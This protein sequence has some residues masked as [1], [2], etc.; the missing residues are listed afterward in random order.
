MTNIDNIEL[1]KV[2]ADDLPPPSIVITVSANKML[3]Y[4]NV[5]TFSDEQEVTAQQVFDKLNDMEIVFGLD[6]NKVIEYCEK[7]KY[8]KEE[9][10][11]SGIKPQKGDDGYYKV[12]FNPDKDLKP[13]ELKDG[14][15]DY[16]DLDLITNVKA[17]EALCELFHFTEGV[18]GTDIYGKPAA[19]T[20]GKNP[21]WPMGK[22]T[23]LGEDDKYILA[24][25][26]G[27]VDIIGEKICV[28]ESMTITTDVGP[29]TGNIEFNG[30]ITI[31]GNV[32]DGY[33][34]K[35]TKCIVVKGVVEGAI[36]EAGEDITIGMGFS[37]MYKGKIKAGRNITAKYIENGTA[38]CRGI[39]RADFAMNSKI[40]SRDSVIMKGRKGAII[41][42]KIVVAQK[43]IAREIGSHSSNNTIVEIDEKW[44]EKE[45]GYISPQERRLQLEGE[46]SK[47]Q[48]NI[49]NTAE[50]IEKVRLIDPNDLDDA[51]KKNKM[52][53]THKLF[54]E[55]TAMMSQLK[56]LQSQ[57]E[58]IVIDEKQTQPKIVC[59]G[60]LHV[61][62]KVVINGIKL[63][64]DQESKN[65]KFYLHEGE[66]VSGQILPSDIEK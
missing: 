2:S 33:S 63:K 31:R 36:V 17:G 54:F 12:L 29:L 61:G 53:I 56:A 13:K 24:A 21:A 42:G 40:S 32:L 66:V 41:N 8:F 58:S 20:P 10:I 34:V 4:L 39:F 28:E 27:A 11:A 64:I 7:K 65:M 18:E 43:I 23:I 15:V 1:N 3:A 25:T 57:L 44:F 60:S 37:G 55:K 45:E 38:E 46:I 47:L 30:N 51:G 52:E 59:Q 49:K 5:R 26:D 19:P 14:T 50:N 6:K 62:T 48:V 9:K 16:K 35:A 22:N